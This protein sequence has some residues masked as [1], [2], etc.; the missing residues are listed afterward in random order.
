MIALFFIGCTAPK[1]P[2]SRKVQVKKI[3]GHYQLYKDGKP[4]HI[5][6]AAGLSHFK[7][8]KEMGGN[9]IRV[10]DTTRLAVILDSAKANQLSVVVGL[11]IF[12]SDYKSFYNDPAKVA[13]QHQ[14]FKAVVNK[15]KQH[16]SLLMWCLGNELDFPFKPSYNSFY[17][18]FNDLTEMIHEDDPD[19]P[20]TTTVLNFNKKYIFNLSVRCDIDLISFNTFG[21]IT[22][23]RDELKSFSWF[24]DGPF[25]VTEWGIDGPWEGT[26]QTAWAAYLEQAS[27]QKAELYQ[28]RYKKSMPTENPGFL[29]SFVFFWGNKQEGTQ[30]WFSIFDE[31]NGKSQAV[32]AMKYIW[33]GK[34]LDY[35]FPQIKNML[36][37]D[38]EAK[39]NI[40]LSA[41]QHFSAEVFLL[42]KDKIK[43]VKWE[44]YPEDWYKKNNLHSDKKLQPL[45]KQIKT[46]QFLENNFV[47]PITEG[48]YRIFATVYD[49][50]GN[51][52]TSNIPFYVVTDK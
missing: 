23:L 18:A 34:H 45:L 24:W 15:Y 32:D 12:N 20:I 38:Q 36:L 9:T 3:E 27:N 14:A 4:Y 22:Y 43:L 11:P 17:K 44:L 50:N 31:Q 28:E 33:T 40:L 39:D 49:D 42:N 52:S 35:T 13:L 37:N 2:G 25:M 8:L 10:W 26:A 47:A 5:K 46:A 16:P 7:T 48:P 41:G 19:H 51:F 6:G 1:D 21:R 29:G 30:T